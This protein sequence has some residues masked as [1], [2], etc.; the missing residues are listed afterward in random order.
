MFLGWRQDDDKKKQ[1][2]NSET[3]RAFEHS[4]VKQ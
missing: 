3:Y 1:E 4:D 2:K